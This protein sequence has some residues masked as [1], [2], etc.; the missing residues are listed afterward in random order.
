MTEYIL[1][2]KK[3]EI[4][5]VYS[6]SGGLKKLIAK[7]GFLSDATKMGHEFAFDE[8]SI[9]HEYWKKIIK[10]NDPFF[11]NAQ[12]EWFD[13]YTK[14]TGLTYR[15]TPADG[16][17]LKEIGKY[18]VALSSSTEAIDIWKQMLHNWNTLDVF[19]R[20]KMQLTFINSNL[21]TI[22]NL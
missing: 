19:Y 15:F 8:Q 5:A 9:E 22:I 7:K 21:N 12:R 14:N 4:V 1:K 11:T 18:L 16:K 13:F 6:K 10:E 20:H 17:A 3:F 2:E